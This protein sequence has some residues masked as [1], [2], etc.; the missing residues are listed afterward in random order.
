MGLVGYAY[1]MILLAPSQNA[2]QR[3]LR[4]CKQFSAQKKI[5]FS[6]DPDP[7]KS[8]SYVV[9]VKRLRGTGLQ[10]PTPLKLCGQDLAWV[11]RA[12]HL[13]HRLS[14]DGTMRRIAREKHAQFI[15]CHSK[16]RG[17]FSFA[18]PVEQLE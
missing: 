13:G 9:Y 15:D 16:S 2:A 5:W 10:K 14:E 4:T 7:V 18:H 12:E 1:N 3:M 17:T 11:T 8:K 6:T